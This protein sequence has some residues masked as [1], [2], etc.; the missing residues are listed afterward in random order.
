MNV[1]DKKGSI[2]LFVLVGLLFMTSF[3]IIS[4]GSNINKSKIAKEQLNILSGIY[5]HRDTDAY[6]RAY[7][8][9]R[10]KYKKP[11]KTSVSNT[12]T[13]ELENTFN[14]RLIDYKIYGNTTYVGK[15]N[16][17][18]RKYEIQIKVTDQNT[19]STTYSIYLSSPLKK[20]GTLVDY[21]DYKGQ[22]VIRNVGT[23]K[24]E[25]IY[26]PDI[27]TFDDYTEIQIVN[28]TTPSKIEVE[29]TGYEFMS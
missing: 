3:L 25:S 23:K 29:Y 7:T 6:D 24:T 18:K 14:D 17:S 5:S 27:Y 28:T 26:L 11:L 1:R 20:S 9:L 2:T 4:F 13:L 10:N 8:D 15:Y 21:I 16:S 22:R 19:N 12:S